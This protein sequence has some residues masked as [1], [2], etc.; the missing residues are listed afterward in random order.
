MH[1]T[2]VPFAGAEA[3][4]DYAWVHQVFVRH[5]PLRRS[6]PPPAFSHLQLIQKMIPVGLE[7]QFASFDAI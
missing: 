3:T 4:P 7:A 5:A 1:Q 6:S 2:S